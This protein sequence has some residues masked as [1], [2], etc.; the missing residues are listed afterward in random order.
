M[1][2][3]AKALKARFSSPQECL[4]KLGL[5]SS[6]LDDEWSTKAKAR[7]AAARRGMAI[8]GIGTPEELRAARDLDGEEF[9]REQRRLDRELEDGMID[10]EEE[11]DEFDEEAPR[12]F[13]GRNDEEERRMRKFRM[14][15]LY[16]HMTAP[17]EEGGQGWAHDDVMDVL[18][19]FPKNG[20]EHMNAAVF[21]EDLEELMGMGGTATSVYEHEPKAKDRRKMAKDAR[22]ATK[23]FGLD[24]LQE[25]RGEMTRWGDR[26][27]LA[28]DERSSDAAAE[29]DAWFG[30]GRIGIA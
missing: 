24:R 17:R 19:D 8:D 10:D 18:R 13:G 11:R 7:K 14:R 1:G 15:Q 25:R 2:A 6:L 22:L 4:A 28:Y 27:P 9:E 21:D 20:L 23:H 5:D 26:E 29:V 16:D 12:F 30:T 3:L